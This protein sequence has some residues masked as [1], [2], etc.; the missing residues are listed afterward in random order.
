MDLST[1][2]TRLQRATLIVV[3]LCLI[4]SLWQA[5]IPWVHCHGTDL[6]GIQSVVTAAELSH[7]LVAFHANSELGLV[8]VDNELGWHFHWILPCWGHAADQTPEDQ[9]PAE[10]CMTFDQA[11]VSLHNSSLDV[12][13]GM[14]SYFDRLDI[15]HVVTLPTTHAE[16]AFSIHFSGREAQFVLR[17]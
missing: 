9:P 17:C 15:S 6:R 13:V 4:V 12:A 8:R 10:E 1:T 11:M 7:H 14:D 3:R 2:P 5:P 16:S